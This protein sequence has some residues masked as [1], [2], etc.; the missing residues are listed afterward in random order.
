MRP[1]VNRYSLQVEQAWIF[2]SEQSPSFKNQVLALPELL[3]FDCRAHF[4]PGRNFS[5]NC[6]EN[7]A[8]FY[9][10]KRRLWAW[11]KS[12]LELFKLGPGL[13]THAKACSTYSSLCMAVVGDTYY[14]ESKVHIKA[15]LVLCNIHKKIEM[16]HTCQYWVGT[17]HH[18]S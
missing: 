14:P 5:L 15:Q 2:N 16:Y 1:V 12:S 18:I 10:V 6:C 8:L 13:W 4:M 3:S 7:W 17:D 11:E 9:V